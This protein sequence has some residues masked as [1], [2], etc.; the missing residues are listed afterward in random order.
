MPRGSPAII[1]ALL[2][3]QHVEFSA[4]L[5]ILSRGA[6]RGTSNARNPPVDPGD[7]EKVKGNQGDGKK[8]KS[9]QGD[10]GGQE[11]GRHFCALEMMKN[12]NVFFFLAG[13]GMSPKLLISHPP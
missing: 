11:I 1:Y 12:K 7:A 3:N 6:D 5:C 8:V 9:N 13:A 4:P 2:K 10:K